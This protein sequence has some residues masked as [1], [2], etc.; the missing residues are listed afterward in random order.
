MATG[1][2]GNAI[3]PRKRVEI[4]RPQPT[5]APLPKGVVANTVAPGAGQD[6]NGYMTS[7]GW[8]TE[9]SWQAQTGQKVTHDVRN[10]GGPGAS[11]TAFNTFDD[12]WRKNNPGYMQAWSDQT[13][14]S[15]PAANALPQ[16]EGGTV[17][18]PP[19]TPVPTPAP[20]APPGMGPEMTPA[21]TSAPGGIVSGALNGEPP[22]ASADSPV[23]Y[24]NADIMA[25][26]QGDNG[27]ALNG[28]VPYQD[29]I[30]AI[31]AVKQQTGITDDMIAAALREA[32]GLQ[33][34]DAAMVA[35]YLSGQEDFFAQPNVP[36]PTPAPTPPP[37]PPGATGDPSPPREWPNTT[38]SGAALLSNPTPWNV[39]ADQTVEGRIAGLI[40]PNNPL[41]VQLRTQVL[42][43]M[44][45]R[46]MANSALAES[47]VQD[48]IIRNAMQ[49]AGMDAQTFAKAAGWNAEQL[50]QFMV[51]NADYENAF[52]TGNL[53]RG[54]QW[55]IAN[56][57]SST[58]KYTADLNSETQKYI[59]GLNSETQKVIATL[60][61]DAQ[62][63]AATVQRD[64][65]NLLETNKQASTSWSNA[66][67]IIANIQMSD[68][69]DGSAKATAIAQVW[70]DLKNQLT[71]LQSVSGIGLNL[72]FAG[73]AGFDA[74]GNWV[75]LGNTG[76]SGG[77]GTTGGPTGSGGGSG[78]GVGG[79]IG[80]E[81]AGP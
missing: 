30:N 5:P 61:I 40:D 37:G 11:N 78:G 52:R 13:A 66:M 43:Q 16:S 64:F 26:L 71:M 17:A 23:T 9:R 12:Q 6:A 53:D 1:I 55:D 60:N 47:A 18:E 77:T 39:T 62:R 80:N 32:T 35:R 29:R 21:P 42:Q 75:G 63:E 79:G 69:M 10:P 56:L 3:T 74:Q 38:T 24:S 58:Q 59:A 15:I 54:L 72:N 19:A 44:N 20:T 27:W 70:N 68:K 4:G 34:V 25:W 36:G 51:R 45:A 33:Y 7:P 41:N 49:I 81:V 2:V 65:Q 48:A 28:S 57:N 22:P 76:T 73:Y 31:N 14:P 50:N 46:G 67:N 8:M